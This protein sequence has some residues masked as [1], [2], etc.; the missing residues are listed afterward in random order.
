MRV[1]IITFFIL[2]RIAKLMF[3]DQPCID[4]KN[5]GIIQGSP[6][7][8]EIFLIGHQRIEGV[9]IKMPVNGVNGFEY[10]IARESYDAR[11]R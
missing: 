11:E 9:N 5:D 7:N 1:T 8:T 3:N 2:G 6:A 10:S 4:E